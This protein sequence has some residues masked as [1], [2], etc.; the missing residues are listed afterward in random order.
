MW[1]YWFSSRLDELSSLLFWCCTDT[2]VCKCVGTHKKKKRKWERIQAKACV[3]AQVCPCQPQS[4][5]QWWAL[6]ESACRYGT[7]LSCQHLSHPRK[8]KLSATEISKSANSED[9]SVV[10][11]IS[12]LTSLERSSHT[13]PST[14]PRVAH[15]PVPSLALHQVSSLIMSW[16]SLF[17][18]Q[19][20][21]WSTEDL[22]KDQAVTEQRSPWGTGQ[23]YHT[24]P[25][26]NV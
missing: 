9:V 16:M 3:P 13:L 4:E 1:F 7:S 25:S 26:D 10:G 15:G 8:G 18:V 12:W 21:N 22:C 20:L 14:S 19:E 24:E 11:L 6:A 17:M 23:H 2:S 5:A